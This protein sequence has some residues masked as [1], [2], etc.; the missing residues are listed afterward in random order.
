MVVLAAASPARG[1]IVGVE[2]REQFNDPDSQW[3]GM[4]PEYVYP[5]RGGSAVAVGYFRLLTARHFSIPDGTK[6]NVGGDQFE[7]VSQAA[8][9][10]DAG[11]DLPPDL[12]ILTLKNNTD[13][14]RPLPG[15]YGLNTQPLTT[16]SDL[17]LA[18]TGY[19]G[20]ATDF[21]YSQDNTTGRELRWG[22]N[23]YAYSLSRT[24][25]SRYT[26]DVFRM[27]FS[28]GET[29]H[30][31]GYAEGDSGGG[32]FVRNAAGSEW[33]LAG[34][35][36]YRF[37][38]ASMG[39]DMTAADI[40]HYAD[41]LY[42]MLKDDLLPGDADCDGN[43]DSTDYLTVKGALGT[44]SGAGWDNGDFDGD[45]DVDNDDLTAVSTNLGYTSTPH[46]IMAPPDGSTA[47]DP[48]AP[49]PATL[50]L[51]SAGAIGLLGRRRKSR[52]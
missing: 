38:S 23:R 48:N 52:P 1:I 21:Y 27:K 47:P 36:L 18:G 30:E 41:Q 33:L 8:L 20:T 44:A 51:L 14:D 4:D 12:R 29:E 34:T 45:G 43:V 10:A 17:V 25:S 39:T 5:V 6:L 46:P 9:P 16:A 31:A 49:E 28:P 37:G 19:S 50:G 22:T 35:H 11:H 3:C 24:W 13:P 40:S 32:A 42:Q 7:V 2:S 26:T 15:F